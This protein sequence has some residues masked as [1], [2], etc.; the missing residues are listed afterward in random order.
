MLFF[1][2]LPNKKLALIYLANDVVQQARAKKRDIFISSFAKVVPDAIGAAYKQVS[3]DVKS[4]IKRVVEVWRQRRIFDETV[5][6][7]IES[8]LNSDAPSKQV[9]GSKMSLGGSLDEIPPSLAKLAKIQ[10]QLTQ[11]TSSSSTS[12]STANKKYSDLYDANT[13]PAP[14]EYAEELNR[15]EPVISGAMG[16]LTKTIRMRHDLLE[17]LQSL[18]SSNGTLLAEEEKQ[19][20]DMKE[21]LTQILETK[22]E[23]Q[24][25]ID[26]ETQASRSTNSVSDPRKMTD[27]YEPAPF[28]A[29][30]EAP[31]YSPISSDSD[32]DDEPANKAVSTEE[33]TEQPSAKKQKIEEENKSEATPMP[34]PSLEGLDPKVAQF[35][36]NLVQENSS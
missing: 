16:A 35:L 18:I 7:N 6:Y 1:S 30:I 32:S 19:L 23:I 13:L 5:L 33:T 21:K 10:T 3:Q 27:S 28:V 17:Q 12:F 4:K 9:I 14:K 8:Q 31:A 20:T 34:A 26:E 25:M 29:D 36:S 2:A 24:E 11:L 15:L 22:K